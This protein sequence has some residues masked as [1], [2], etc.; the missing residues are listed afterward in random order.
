M[1]RPMREIRPLAVV[2]SGFLLWSAAFLAI[3][4]AQATGC[5]LGW[6]TRMLLGPVSILRAVLLGLYALVLAGHAAILLHLGADQ[7]MAVSADSE[8]V[9]FMR[10]A[11]RRLSI[12]S[13]VASTLCFAGVVW[14]TAC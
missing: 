8:T 2:I 5:G 1:R 4:G 14:L 7:P 10:V 13:A 12:L 6:D 9:D 11:A 3:Y